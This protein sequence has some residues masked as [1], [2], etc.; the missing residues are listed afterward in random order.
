MDRV[1]GGPLDATCSVGVAT[2]V[3]SAETADLP[4]SLADAGCR[5]PSDG[6]G[7][8]VQATP[9]EA[10]TMKASLFTAASSAERGVRGKRILPFRTF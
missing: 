1:L 5:A 10:T 3:G 4:E 9:S 7:D 2:F 6:G 8:A